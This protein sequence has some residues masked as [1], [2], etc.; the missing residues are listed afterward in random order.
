MDSSNSSTNN[1]LL[2]RA[3]LR[4]LEILK[5]FDEICKTNNIQYWLIAG[6]LLG[7]V[8]HKGFIPWDDDINVAFCHKDLKKIRKI[9]NK[10]LPDN[11]ALQDTTTDKKYYLPSVIKIRDRNSFFPVPTHKPFK[12]QG[13]FIDIIPME[14]IP[15][16][17]FKRFVFNLNKHP[18]LR[19]KEIAFNSKSKNLKGLFLQ[20]L[21]FIA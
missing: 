2:R 4:L 3:Q 11:L 20:P 6:T 1:I 13:L 18:Y 17:R 7:A 16:Q 5:V 21:S 12:H 8:R 15:S 9:L 19:Q 14:K 10:E